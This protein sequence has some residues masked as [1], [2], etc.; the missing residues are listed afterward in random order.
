MRF[1]GGGGAKKK[2]LTF[3]RLYTNNSDG[4]MFLVD[5]DETNNRD[6]F[7][8]C[9]KSLDS[10]AMNSYV[11]RKYVTASQEDHPNDYL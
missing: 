10:Y 5:V 4:F 9:L 3:F 2:K 11:Y 7:K 6:G 1:G 8:I